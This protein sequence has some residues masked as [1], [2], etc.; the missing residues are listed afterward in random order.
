M[1]EGCEVTVLAR[2]MCQMH[3]ARWRKR[4][5]VGG[6][7]R[8]SRPRAGLCTIE[9]CSKT[10][11]PNGRKGMCTTHYFRQLKG[12]GPQWVRPDRH[13]SDVDIAWLTGIFEGEGCTSVRADRSGVMS[14]KLTVNMTDE[15]I[16]RRLASVTGV[17]HVYV[18]ERVPENYKTIY[19]WMVSSQRDVAQLLLAMAPLFG[20]RRRAR[21]GEAAAV[22]RTLTDARRV[23]EHNYAYAVHARTN[24]GS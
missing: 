20:H 13:M 18:R 10:I 16:I 21:A 14:V 17:G 2:G 23:R 12:S 9:G 8:L 19:C 4:G 6:P 22:L 11:L 3:Y 24:P 5:D 7:N 15:D 1:V